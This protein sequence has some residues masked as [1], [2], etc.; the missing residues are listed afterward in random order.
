MK[1]EKVSKYFIFFSILTFITIFVFVIQQSYGNLMKPINEIQN[2]TLLKPIDPNL[3]S[4]ILDQ[5]DQKH[6]YSVSLEGAVEASPSSQL[7]Q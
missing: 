1:K 7:T 3:D 2:N 5:I 6:K 4:G